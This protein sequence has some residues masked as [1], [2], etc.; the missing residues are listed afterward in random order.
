MNK[1]PQTLFL[2]TALALAVVTGSASVLA[3]TT[4]QELTDVRQETQ[5]WTSYALNPYL[6]A[7]DLSV[8]V[9][10]GK[11]T[12]TGHVAEDVNKALANEIALGVKGIDR[13]DNQIVVDA[14]YMPTRP[15][16]ERSF[17][18]TVDD[19][20][21]TA[22]V[23]AKLMWSKNADAISTHVVT[24][25]GRVVLRGTA[26]SGEARDF[27]GRL[28][29]DTRGVVSVDNQLQIKP[30]P[31]TV[32][33]SSKTA[34]DEAGTELTDSWITTRVKSTL[35]YSSNVSGSAI[36]V[37]TD[38]GVVSLSGQVSSGSERALAVELAQN[39][40]GVRRVESAAL[41]F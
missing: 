25:Y 41:A 10:S 20:S 18:D 29:S 9:G 36:D 14:D 16:A 8:S 37:S 26:Q 27:A 32:M 19:A 40:R 23:K 4:S 24:R 11:A 30:A 3:E 17:G 6:R 1:N 15:G 21:I 33:Q 38:K 13:V 12:L 35:L 39:V 28:A 31:A 7:H 2:I 34:I 22:A 5:I